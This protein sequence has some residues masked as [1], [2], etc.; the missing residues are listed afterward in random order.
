M[1]NDNNEGTLVL[2]LFCGELQQLSFCLC[3]QKHLY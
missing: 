1:S 2:S 3:L